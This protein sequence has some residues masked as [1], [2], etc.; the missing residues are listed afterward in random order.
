MLY[1]VYGDSGVSRATVFEWYKQFVEVRKDDPKTE[2]PSTSKTNANI[3]MI[4]QLICSDHQLTICVMADEPEIAKEIVRISLMEKLGM[5]N[6]N[7]V[8]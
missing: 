5:Q 4:C 8:P 6:L 7:F 3:E 1:E 2:R